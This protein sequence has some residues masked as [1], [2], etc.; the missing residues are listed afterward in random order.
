MMIYFLLSLGTSKLKS[1]P[2]KT[3]QHIQEHLSTKATRSY[4]DQQN[5]TD[6]KLSDQ[7]K[8]QASKDV[9]RKFNT[10][11]L[12]MSTKCNIDNFCDS[13]KNSYGDNAFDIVFVNLAMRCI[14]KALSPGIKLDNLNVGIDIEDQT[15]KIIS[16]YH[17]RTMDE[18]HQFFVNKVYIHFK[19]LSSVTVVFFILR[20]MSKL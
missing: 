11:H 2:S 13:F 12:S 6:H 7:R 8:E 4:F 15:P 16:N 5:F 1:A 14:T 18:V 20:I 10:P 17:H 3:T 9:N 19:Y